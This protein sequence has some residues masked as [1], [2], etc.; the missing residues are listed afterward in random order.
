[1]KQL[2]LAMQLAALCGC[3]GSTIQDIANSHINANVPPDS[4]FDRIL[5]RDL[6][7]YF[8]AKIH[9]AI[10]VEYELLR[11]GA[12]QTGIAY[13]KFYA[14]V[15]ARAGD[16]VLD[17][18]AVRLAAI[19]RTKFD[20]TDFVSESDIRTRPEGIYEVFPVPVCEK[21]KSRLGVKP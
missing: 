6:E 9:Q 17:Q 12:T 13:P 8:G 10:T 3:G 18:G 5:R 2:V 7:S 1:M 21:I 20:V 11:E 14:W 19:G 16:A 15:R 4:E